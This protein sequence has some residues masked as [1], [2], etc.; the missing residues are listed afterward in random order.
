MS[1]PVFVHDDLAA[2]IGETLTLR[3]PEGRHAVTVTRTAVGDEVQLIDG[4]GTR[5]TGTVTQTAG[6][7]VLTVEVS[8][9]EVEPPPRPEVTIVQALPKSERSEL[10]VDLATQAGADT[11]VAWQ[12]RRC[13]AKWRGAKIDKHLRKWEDAAYAAAKQSRRSRIPRIEGPLSTAELAEYLAG[14]NAYVLHE[15]AQVG[16]GEVDLDVDKLVVIVGPEGGIGAEELAEL[17]ATPVR[18]GPEVYRTA[19]AAMVTLAAI[20]ALTKRW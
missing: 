5:I 19:S 18:L 9:R 20:G 2:D 1:L 4:R 12:A 14:Q 6:K 7:D 16:I 3:G 15:D 13:V 11:I 8:A 10:A 17:G